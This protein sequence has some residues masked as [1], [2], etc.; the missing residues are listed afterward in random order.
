LSAALREASSE[1]SESEDP[2]VLNVWGPAYLPAT[3]VDTPGLIVNPD[4]F[5]ST[6]HESAVL[7]ALSVPN[8]LIAVVRPSCVAVLPRTGNDYVLDTVKK[9]DPQLAR[10]VVITT[11]L[12]AT[13]AN[14][15]SARA[16]SDTFAASELAAATARRTFFL[17][18]PSRSLRSEITGDVSKYDAMLSALDAKDIAAFDRLRPD[19]RFAESLGIAAATQYVLS[20][21]KRAHEA[22]APRVLAALRR[23][24]RAAAEEEGKEAEKAD[25]REAAVKYELRFLEALGELMRGSG[26]WCGETAKEEEE[27][28]EDDWAGQEEGNRAGQRLQGLEAFERLLE[29]FGKVV[30]GKKMVH[31]VIVGK[32]AVGSG[33]GIG[34]EDKG[35]GW[36]AADIG[37]A[38]AEEAMKP[39]IVQLGRRAGKVFGRLGDYAAEKAGQK[40]VRCEL[41][42]DF[43]KEEYLGF[44]RDVCDKCTK[45]CM[46]EF[47]STETVFWDM[48][49]NG[50]AE[51]TAEVANIKLEETMG[52]AEKVFNALKTR[53]AQNVVER[54]YSSLVFSLD[55]KLAEYMQKKVTQIDDKH[56]DELFAAQSVKKSLEEEKAA[57]AIKRKK[58]EKEEKA[59]IVY[60]QKLSHPEQFADE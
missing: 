17:T 15:T 43:I 30:E 12:S 50:F 9:V 14:A 59:C 53:I 58:L 54:F 8:A 40:Q 13:L 4:E 48:T 29:A 51:F 47:H 28:E 42:G 52:A 41:F 56:L 39:L 49:H 44:V 6:E 32:D 20:A 3:F 27:G 5:G 26:V 31:K 25:L 36:A 2:I 7:R 37:R 21:V 60:S 38:A 33:A 18:L 45:E 10:T 57:A 1:S 55:S 19:S 34:A 46:E 11:G 23:A 35:Y 22:E 24:R 16:A